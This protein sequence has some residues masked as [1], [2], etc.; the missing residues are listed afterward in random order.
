MV[1]ETVLV[2]PFFFYERK[3]NVSKSI[4][5]KKKQTLDKVKG[6]SPCPIMNLFLHNFELVLFRYLKKF[7]KKKNKVHILVKDIIFFCVKLF[8]SNSKTNVVRD[9]KIYNYKIMLILKE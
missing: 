4:F 2:C 6:I 5:V 7:V 1:I 3:I 9:I 8:C